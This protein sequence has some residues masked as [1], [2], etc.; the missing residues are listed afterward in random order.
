MSQFD[1]R[2]EA[3]LKTP[4]GGPV[5]G[6]EFDP[7]GT[8]PTGHPDVDATVASLV[9]LDAV[10]PAEQVER[11]GEAHRSLQQILRTIDTA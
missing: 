5:A 10:P 6:G 1:N 7:G 3:Q 11:Y 9:D 2:F 8:L 4:A